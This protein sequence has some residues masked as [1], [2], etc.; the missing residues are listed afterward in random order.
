MIEMM[1]ILSKIKKKNRKF[2]SQHN[3]ITT[4]FKMADY[5]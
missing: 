2:I 5:L 1:I 4:D 3:Y